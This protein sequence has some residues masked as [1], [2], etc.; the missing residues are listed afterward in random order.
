MVVVSDACNTTT[1]DELF[2]GLNVT[3][4]TYTLGFSIPV[5]I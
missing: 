5:A 2:F 3:N 4:L 1:W